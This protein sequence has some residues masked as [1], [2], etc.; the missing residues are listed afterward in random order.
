MNDIKI[1]NNNRTVSFLQDDTYQ[2][3]EFIDG[4]RSVLHQGTLA[5]IEAYVRLEERGLR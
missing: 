1:A 2:L 4:Q 5:E 3:V